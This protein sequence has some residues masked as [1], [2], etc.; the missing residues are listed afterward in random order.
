MKSS[1]PSRSPE[2]VVGV[3]GAL[4]V[5]SAE[6]WRVRIV[7]ALAQSASVAVDLAA[8]T[9]IDVFGLQLLYAARCSADAQGKTFRAFNAGPVVES[10]CAAAGIDPTAVGL[11]P[12]RQPAATAGQVLL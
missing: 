1:S 2:S 11:L 10:A 4:T 12:S 5:G 7:E 3:D 9:E 8:T 6:S